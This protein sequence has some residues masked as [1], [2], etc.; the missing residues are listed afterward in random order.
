MNDDE[1]SSKVN[2]WL[3]LIS[4]W[5][6]STLAMC[7]YFWHIR[8]KLSPPVGVYEGTFLWIGLVLFLVPFFSTIRIGKVLELERGISQTRDEVKALK[9]DV[10]QQVLLLNSNISAATSNSTIINKINTISE[11]QTTG[12]K[13]LDSEQLPGMRDGISTH[14]ESPMVSHYNAMALKILNTLW[15]KQVNKFPDLKYRFS[16]TV[17]NLANADVLSYLYAET[18]LQKDRLIGITP[19]GQFY[20]T[21]IGLRYCMNNYQ[22]FPN[23]SWYPEPLDNTKLQ[24]AKKHI[25]ALNS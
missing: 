4:C 17:N 21:D 24:E 9:E 6:M 8:W 14:L 18:K 5:L 12:Q 2:Y 7:A 20:L 15:V 3:V 16:F 13:S 1:R 19:E 11:G 25:S 10:K 23:D 22:H